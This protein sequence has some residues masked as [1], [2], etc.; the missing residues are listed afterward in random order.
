M[1]PFEAM[2]VVGV[3][4]DELKVLNKSDR[5]KLWMM[6]SMTIELSQ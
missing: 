2:R 6:I 4:R 1:S 5:I 3:V